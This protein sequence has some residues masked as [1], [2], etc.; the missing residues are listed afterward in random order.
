[1]AM[2]MT[3]GLEYGGAG[4][5]VSVGKIQVLEPPVPFSGG[6]FGNDSVLIYRQ[7]NGGT[8]NMTPRPVDANGLSATDSLKNALPGKNQVIDTSKFKSL[9][10][11][12]DN[13]KTGH[14]SIVPKDMSQMQGWVR[15]R[16]SVEIHPLT[17]ELR[18]AIIGTVKK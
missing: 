16:E 8:K 13:P 2:A 6:T 7:G 3:I 18:D 17:Q 5:P 14:V 11:T 1:M 10:A 15:S 9:C 4:G 12:C